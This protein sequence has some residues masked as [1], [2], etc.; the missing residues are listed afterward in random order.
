MDP[1]SIAG[2]SISIAG[3]IGKA[4][5]AI[6][7]FSREARDATDDLSGIE[8]ELNALR[9]IV[10]ALAH[11]LLGPSDVPEKL[12]QKLQGSLEGCLLVVKQITELVGR[13]SR[14]GVWTRTKWVLVGQGD[15]E[16]LRESLSS[17]K[18][19][20]GLGLHFVSQ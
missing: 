4:S 10:D 17:Y 5:L 14:E 12:V 13:Y 20:L 15:M 11:S 8:A 1:L 18:M 16:K 19:A 9:P 3:A 7:H 2:A 6:Y